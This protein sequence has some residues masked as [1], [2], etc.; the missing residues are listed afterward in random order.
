MGELYLCS[1]TEFARAVDLDTG[2][3]VA[4]VGAP[5]EFPEWIHRLLPADSCIVPRPVDLAGHR[6][7]SIVIWWLRDLEISETDTETIRSIVING[8]LWMVV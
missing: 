2:R 8:D 3:T 1:R 6:E 7:F 5:K 4:I